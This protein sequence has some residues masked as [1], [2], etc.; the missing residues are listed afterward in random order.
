[1]TYKPIKD[2]YQNNDSLTVVNLKKRTLRQAIQEFGKPI[3]EE[4]FVLD[5]ALTEFRIGLYNIFS[6]EERMSRSIYLEEVTWEKDAETNITA[7][8]RKEPENQAAID[9]FE[10]KKTSEF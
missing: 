2:S 8:Y 7:W 5:E 1:M 9:A 6:K 3:R 4:E 10:W